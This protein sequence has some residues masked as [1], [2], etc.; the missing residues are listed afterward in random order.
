MLTPLGWGTAGAAVL[1]YAAALPLGYAEPAVLACGAALALAGALCWTAPRARL[2]VHREITPLKV[3]RGD[4]A[5]AVLH[6]ANEGRRTLSGLRA[7]DRF[8]GAEQSVDVPRIAKATTRAV[9]YPLPTHARGEIAVGPLTLVRADPLGLTRRVRQYGEAAT[10]LVRPRTA[11]LPVLPSGRA[12]NLEGPT[13]DNAP[14]GTATFHTL[15]EYVVGDDLR[16]V[17]WRSSARTGT[18]MVRQLVDVSLPGTTVVLDT[19]PAAYASAELF[20]TAVDAAASVAVA[21]ARAGFPVRLVTGQGV[22]ADAKGGPQDAEAILDRLATVVAGGGG[23]AEAVRLAR[24]GG[25]LVL[26][27]G[28]TPEATDGAPQTSAARRRF[29]R[30]VLLRATSGA[31][32]RPPAPP[33]VTVMDVAVLDELPALW[34]GAA[35]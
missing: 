32:P 22:L 31:A 1:L 23:A 26:V 3:P 17:H 30:V 5:V 20:E 16:H 29:D 8:G 15:R 19:R 21:A 14:A 34:R 33:G 28:D 2:A 10:L 7:R 25:A 12:P 11:E 18:L 6:I 9:T 24:G 27:T 35:R 13:G 4:A